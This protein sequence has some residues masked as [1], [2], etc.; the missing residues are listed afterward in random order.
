MEKKRA[1]DAGIKIGHLPPG[2]NGA[3]T[4]VAGVSGTLPSCGGTG[5]HGRDSS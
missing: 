1:R 3:I 4:D 5:A 2:P